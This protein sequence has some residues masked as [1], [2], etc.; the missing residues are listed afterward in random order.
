MSSGD[1]IHLD[2]KICIRSSVSYSQSSLLKEL[3]LN[4]L[5]E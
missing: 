5:Q 3:T 4:L 1:D 2:T